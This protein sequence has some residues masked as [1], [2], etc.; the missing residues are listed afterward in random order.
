MKRLFTIAILLIA[1]QNL[2][3]QDTIVLYNGDAIHG[4]IKS[5]TKGV[6]KIETSYSDSDFKVEWLHVKSIYSKRTF[7]IVLEDGEKPVGNIN[8]I[9]SSSDSIEVL[10]FIAFAH[11]PI[12]YVVEITPLENSFIGRLDAT[13]DIGFY[14][15]KA[16]KLTQITSSGSFAYFSDKWGG[17]ATF[18]ILNSTQ[19]NTIPTKRKE[20]DMSFRR[21]LKGKIYG[22]LKA[23]FLHNNE[24]QLDLRST[25]E[26]GLGT[27]FLNTNT[28]NMGVSLGG[29]FNNEK[30][31]DSLSTEKQSVEGFITLTVDLFDT[32]DLSF[33]MEGTAYPSITEKGRVRADISTNLKY[34]LPFDFYFKV[35]YTHNFDN[36]PVEGSPE[37]D[38]VFQSS[39][40][41]EL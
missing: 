40:G 17:K 16:N 34:D 33:F 36:Q 28:T 41:W 20:A 9:S 15:A 4:E 23:N 25:Y 29:A 18:N 8:S 19:E 38:Y 26:L 31:N 27:F 30:Y 2:F 10:E 13:L 35:S 1:F 32:G 6:L 12:H 7:S 24:I 21:N 39:I 3:A 22:L 11:Y 14:Y 37:N 5:L